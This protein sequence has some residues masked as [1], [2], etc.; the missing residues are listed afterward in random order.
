MR[1]ALINVPKA[2]NSAHPPRRRCSE[3]PV[4]S[5]LRRPAVET[6]NVP[7][8]SFSVLKFVPFDPT[9]KRTEATLRAPSGE[10]FAVSKG[11]P[12]VITAL[13]K[14]PEVKARAAEVVDEYAARGYRTLGVA[15]TAP[16]KA[17][18]DTPSTEWEF[19]GLLSLYDPPR[20][21]TAATISAAQA[22]PTR[23]N[24][25]PPMLLLEPAVRSRGA[26]EA[27]LERP[28]RLSPPCAVQG[29]GIEVKM[30]TGDHIAIAK[31]TSRLLGLHTNIMKTDIL[32]QREGM[33]DAA[34]L[35]THGAYVEHADGF[36][37]VMPEH[38][39]SIVDVL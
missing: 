1:P 7:V 8:T 33:G 15:R 19:L 25:S 34:F 9:R 32:L 24:A 6:A 20:D 29:L 3:V 13:V 30:V 2:S 17:S 31:E 14:D 35:A 11:S 12:Q 22:G 23:P 28:L 38:K 39:F 21:D 4:A 26:S 37:E 10:V 16:T 18:G 36:A 5:R 27:L